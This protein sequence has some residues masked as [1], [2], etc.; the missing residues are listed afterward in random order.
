MGRSGYN[1]DCDGWALIRWRGAVKQAIRGKRGQVF[2]REMRDAL[3]A[4]PEKKLASSVLVDEGKCCAMGAVAL[5]RGIDTSCVDPFERE[6]VADLFGI[7]E[8]LA[9]EIAYENDDDFGRPIT[10]EERWAWMRRWVEGQ[11]RDEASP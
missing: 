5:K 6:Q 9:A 7:S 11:I 8:A 1:E 4:L 2:L 10:D 3:D